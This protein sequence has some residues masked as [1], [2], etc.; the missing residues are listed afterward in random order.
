MYIFKKKNVLV[1]SQL[2]LQWCIWINDIYGSV[3]FRN[4]LNKKE[5]KK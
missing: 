4:K 3:F 2:L 1:V 5:N